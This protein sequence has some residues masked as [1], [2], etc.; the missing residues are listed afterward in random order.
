MDAEFLDPTSLFSQIESRSRSVLN[1]LSDPILLHRFQSSDPSAFLRSTVYRDGT[2]LLYDGPPSSVLS[3]DASSAT[4]KFIITT[5]SKDRY[6]DVVL[7]RGCEPHLETYRNNPV[8]FFSHRSGG[9]PIG[10]SVD[11]SGNFDLQIDDNRITSSVRFHLK[12][13][14]SEQ[15]FA[16]V[17]AGELRTASIGFLPKKAKVF[18]RKEDDEDDRPRNEANFEPW[19]TFSF[20]EFELYEWSVVSVPANPDCVS[21]RL[22]KGIDGRPLSPALAEAFKPYAPEPRPW[23]NGFKP[24]K[25]EMDPPPET[26][27]PGNSKPE[28]GNSGSDSPLPHGASFLM[29]CWVGNAWMASWL[30]QMIQIIEQ[31]QV[32][33]WAVAEKARLVDANKQIA[34]AGSE[35]Y[36]DLDWSSIPDS[37][38]PPW[39]CD[40]DGDSDNSQPADQKSLTPAPAPAPALAP[41]PSGS[42][43]TVEQ[44]R[45]LFSFAS[46]NQVVSQPAFSDAELR[47]FMEMARLMAEKMDS[48]SR[49]FFELTGRRV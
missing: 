28:D 22:S 5:R 2:K 27:T 34:S 6:G 26:Q 42:G 30:D 29:S 8:V 43:L 20:E 7:P 38:C 44:L 39:Q 32:N 16:L 31:P 14:E 17:H 45:H 36:P 13:Q 24:V 46:Q 1:T 48:V 18:R 12:T 47:S 40:A 15:V 25:K 11:K 19:V 10:S 33:E 3:S 23:A 41:A 35:W 21:M 37:I 4:A 9:M 49:S